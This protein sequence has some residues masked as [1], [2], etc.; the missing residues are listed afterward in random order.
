[1]DKHIFRC[2]LESVNNHFLLYLML[3]FR[4]GFVLRKENGKIYCIILID[5]KRILKLFDHIGKIYF[6][7]LL[8]F[9]RARRLKANI[10]VI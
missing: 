4:I 10:E 7:R 8:R 3:V 5:S 6:N 2:I 9:I 1:L